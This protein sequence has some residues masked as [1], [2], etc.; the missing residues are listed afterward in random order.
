VRL[1]LDE[2]LPAGVLGP[3]APP[4]HDVMTVGEERLSGC[5]DQS[6][7]EV[8]RAERRVLVTLDMDF[9]NPL[10][11]PPEASAGIIVLRPSRPLLTVLVSMLS[12]AVAAATRDA[13]VGKLWIVEPTRIRVYEPSSGPSER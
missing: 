5:E 1:K 7:Y 11:F 10:R 8:C 12:N 2:N 4:G 3:T 9:A 13:V 6:L